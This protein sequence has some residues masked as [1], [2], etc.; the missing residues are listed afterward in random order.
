MGLLNDLRLLLRAPVGE[1][2][3][4][5]ARPLDVLVALLKQKDDDQAHHRKK[6]EQD[7]GL[8][9]RAKP[10]TRPEGLGAP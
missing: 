6:G 3:G 2:A 10:N 5:I 7:E 4:G 8:E 1:Q 9:A